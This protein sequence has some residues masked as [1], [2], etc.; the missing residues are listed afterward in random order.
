[1]Y[2][3]IVLEFQSEIF[4]HIFQ[5]W[6]PLR[7]LFQLHQHVLESNIPSMVRS[8]LNLRVRSIP[9][10]LLKATHKLFNPFLQSVL[11]VTETMLK[12]CSLA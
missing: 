10:P 11:D 9:P 8:L 4:N 5:Q 12:Q 2:L 3:K 1:M 7:R 6:L